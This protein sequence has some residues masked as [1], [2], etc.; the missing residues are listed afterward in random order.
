MEEVVLPHSGMDIHRYPGD[1]GITKE[2]EVHHID[3]SLESMKY[4]E[5]RCATKIKKWMDKMQLKMNDDKTEFIIFSSR[6]Q[7]PKTIMKHLTV[8]NSEIKDQTVSN[9]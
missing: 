6:R 7:L 4:E 2:F 8:N 9:T 3:H 5:W 1:H